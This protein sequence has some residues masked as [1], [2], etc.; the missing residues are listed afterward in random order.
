MGNVRACLAKTPLL[1]F[2]PV[3]PLA[4]FAVVRMLIYLIG[5]AGSTERRLA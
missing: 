3:A 5:N 4:R 2:W 1:Q